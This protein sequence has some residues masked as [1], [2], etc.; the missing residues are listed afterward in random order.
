MLALDSGHTIGDVAAPLLIYRHGFVQGQA[1]VRPSLED[2]SSG[3]QTSI[4]SVSAGLHTPGTHQPGNAILTYPDALALKSLVHFRATI[5]AFALIEYPP[6]LKQQ[7]RI[8]TG[9][10]PGLAIDPGVI[11][12]TRDIQVVTQGL[13]VVFLLVFPDEPERFC[14][15][16]A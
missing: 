10:L 13:Y 12:G 4:D 11:P 15:S 3:E 7:F 2:G 1:I 9:P 5:P 16:S 6:Y 8:L 14:R